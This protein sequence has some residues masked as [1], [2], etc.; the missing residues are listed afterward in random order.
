[1]QRVRILYHLRSFV[2]LH[3]NPGFNDKKKSRTRSMQ[4]VTSLQA[5]DCI[6]PQ[7]NVVAALGAS[8]IFGSSLY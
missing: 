8:G 2:E 1:M 6:S 5:K 3:V 4:F 7:R